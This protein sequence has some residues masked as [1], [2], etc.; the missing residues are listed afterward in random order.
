MRSHLK[1]VRAQTWNKLD[2]TRGVQDTRRNAWNRQYGGTSALKTSFGWTRR[3]ERS[4]EKPGKS[5]DKFGQILGKTLEK[6]DLETRL[7]TN[8]K[9][10]CKSL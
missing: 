10:F 1:Q 3:P 8:W 2:A 9:Q 7:E 4:L 6:L 5:F